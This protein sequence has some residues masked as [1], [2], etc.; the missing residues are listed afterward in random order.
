MAYGDFKD[1]RK[2]TASDKIIH[3][4]AFD[5]AKNPKY[6]GCQRGLPS[7]VYNFFL[8]WV[9]INLLV[10]QEKKINFE[11]QQLAEKLHIPIT[12]KFKK[13]KVYSSFKDNIWGAYL[14]ICN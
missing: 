4:K 10:T 12:R 14:P 6:D 3:D 2:G 1:L 7:V 9:Q 13:R 8:L 11:N 5:L